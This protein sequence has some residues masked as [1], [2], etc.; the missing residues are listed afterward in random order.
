[1]SLQGTSVPYRKQTA[2][3]IPPRNT[4]ATPTPEAPPVCKR[5]TAL[6]SR[7]AQ[8]SGPDARSDTPKV[9]GS[10]S[11]RGRKSPWQNSSNPG[12]CIRKFSTFLVWKDRKASAARSLSQFKTEIILSSPLFPLGP[13]CIKVS[14]HCSWKELIL[15]SS[16][17]WST[18]SL[19]TWHVSL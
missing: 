4:A 8:D 17:P 11:P 12:I 9:L 1:M 16:F 7:P 3:S 5:N 19:P 15:Q 6:P 18:H 14:E 2:F 10:R 13:A